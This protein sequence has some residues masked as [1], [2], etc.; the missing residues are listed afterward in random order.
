M[1]F[2]TQ[3]PCGL[4]YEDTPGERHGQITASVPDPHSGLVCAQ[5]MWF[6]LYTHIF[7]FGPQHVPQFANLNQPLPTHKMKSKVPYVP[8]A[9][10]MMT[11][12]IELC[13]LTL[14]WVNT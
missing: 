3:T 9:R 7:R 6:P 10:Q 4:M 11:F 2:L 5:D 1:Q 8:T 12:I 14:V 13:F